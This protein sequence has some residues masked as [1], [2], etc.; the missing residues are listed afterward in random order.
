MA[1]FFE[2]EKSPKF[3]CEFCDYKCSKNNEWIRHCSTK[4]H[5]LRFAATEKSPKSPNQLTCNS[6]FKQYK[7]RSGLW[8]HKKSCKDDYKLDENLSEEQK[9]EDMMVIML[10][11]NNN[12][13]KQIIE[14]LSKDKPAPTIINNTNNT[15]CNINKFNLNFFLNEQC[16]DA[17]NINDFVKSIQLQ[18]S[19]LETTGKI[20]YVEGISKIL[21]KNLKELDTFRRPIHCSDLKRE[22]LYIKDDNKW[23]KEDDEKHKFKSVIRHVAN[24]NIKQ[25]SKWVEQNPSCKDPESKKNDEYMQLIYNNVL[26]GTNEENDKNYSKIIKNVTKEVIIDK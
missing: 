4:K 8:R 21:I 24:Q 1:T 5:N 10:N 16:K 9:K 25:I 11:Q 13:Q 7:N 15:N 20:G 17:L 26:G 18:V 12:L 3:S 2:T 6:C 14:L 19:D 23:S 22:I